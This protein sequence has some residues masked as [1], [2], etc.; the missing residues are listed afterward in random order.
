MSDSATTGPTINPRLLL[1]APA[2]AKRRRRLDATH[3][4]AARAA[5]VAA[6]LA[7]AVTALVALL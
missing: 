1:P 3:R 5:T 2:L 7:A 6:V 4:V